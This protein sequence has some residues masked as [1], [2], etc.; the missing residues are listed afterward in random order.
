MHVKLKVSKSMSMGVGAISDIKESMKSEYMQSEDMIRNKSGVK[1]PIMHQ[2]FLNS[3]MK[4][5]PKTR[6]KKKI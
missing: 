4:H 6:R 3:S 1:K 2:T 5:G